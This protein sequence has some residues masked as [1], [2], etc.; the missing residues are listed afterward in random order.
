MDKYDKLCADMADVYAG[1]MND[2]G[3]MH[4]FMKECATGYIHSFNI[5]A[6]CSMYRLTGEKKYLT[7]VRAWT[8]FSIRMQGTYGDS[9]AYN[10]GYLFTAPG[11]VPNSWFCADTLDQGFALLNV[12]MILE[13]DDPLYIK[14]LDSV[15]R[16][17]S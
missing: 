3:A 11:N 12:A 17:E 9:A 2:C 10:M 16:Y 1:L 15:L 13:P 4:V 7:A 8:D 5:R 14:I 6:L